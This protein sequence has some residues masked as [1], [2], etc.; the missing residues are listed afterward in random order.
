MKHPA[1]KL[2]FSLFALQRPERSENTGQKLNPFRGM[3]YFLIRWRV[4]LDNIDCD[5][6][7]LAYFLKIKHIVGNCVKTDFPGYF[8]IFRVGYGS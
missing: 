1:V 7:D 2:I 3:K 8:L 6:F 4:V 5:A